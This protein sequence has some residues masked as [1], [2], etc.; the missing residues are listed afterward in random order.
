M[1][2]DLFLIIAVY[3]LACMA[4]MPYVK[5]YVDNP[6][7][8]QYVNIA[9][10]ILEGRFTTA[11][12]GYWGPLISWLLIPFI[13]FFDDGIVAFKFLQMAVGIFVI[14]RW[15][16]F[17]MFVD[18]NEKWKR[19]L[20]FAIVPFM[21]SYSLLNLTPDLLFMGL[22]FSLMI[23]L[24]KWLEKQSDGDRIGK[25]GALMFL[26]KAFGLPLF[27]FLFCFVVW[28][29]DERIPKFTL[30]KILLPFVTVAG[31]WII[32][33][34]LKYGKF[35]VS[36]SARFNFTYE[37]A[38]TVGKQV[39][40]PVLGN[41]LLKP[42]NEFAISAWEEPASQI[43]LTPID[44]V[45]DFAYYLS[46]INRNLQSIYF[47]DFRNQLGW[48]FIF[49]LIIFLIRKRSHEIIPLWIKISLLVICTIYIGYSLILVH[50]RY[51]WICTLLFIPTTFYFIEKSLPANPGISQ[52]RLIIIIPVLILLLKRPTKEVLMCG[53]RN[54]NSLQL[55]HA[56]FSPKT[57]MS[58]F[59]RP[60]IELHS[61]IETM[62][63]IIPPGSTFA[64]IKR[65]DTERDGYAQS[66]LIAYEL[67]GKYLGQTV[68]TDSAF[69]GYL[70]S[71]Q[72]ESG[73]KVFDGD[74]G[75]KVFR[76]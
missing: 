9:H 69:T 58:I 48:I 30:K 44:P 16:R 7:S 23:E 57:T 60:D 53:D 17:L 39:Q 22:L 65:S 51:I 11:I 66:Q 42:A 1:K 31:V 24:I 64:S 2:K 37:V 29:K 41:G 12:N 8:L 56:Y 50:E 6:D 33:L 32:L 46:I 13:L 35:T 68:E 10:H 14:M 49:F 54:V 19:Y 59:Y 75:V 38:P 40:L 61:A 74:R 21:V 18:V 72:V 67:H 20:G 15:L 28:M 55:Y 76:R 5:W 45:K 71:W 52:I 73:E 27:I 3:L 47:H 26:T 63:R 43:T 4:V 62:R 25:T 34:S 70:I 36:E